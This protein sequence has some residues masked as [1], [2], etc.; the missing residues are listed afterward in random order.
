MPGHADDLVQQTLLRAFVSRNQL[1]CPSKFR[2]WIWSIAL[3]EIR[4]FF[5]RSRA[6]VPL[7]ELPIR[8]LT[9]KESSPLVQYVQ[10]ERHGCL[11]AAMAGLAASHRIAIRLVDLEGLSCREA[12][13][14]LRVST[15]AFKSTHYRALERLRRALRGTPQASHIP[16]NLSKAA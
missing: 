6:S 16:A 3:N 11:Q 15:A 10:L 14:A 1:R 12:A 9:D 13:D 8:D 4:M 2:S 7:E 5:R